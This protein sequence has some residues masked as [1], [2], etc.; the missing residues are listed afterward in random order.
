MN[1]THHL[2]KKKNHGYET[3]SQ[4]KRNSQSSYQLMKETHWLYISLIQFELAP[5]AVDQQQ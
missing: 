4:K 5:K 1:E 3:E 2:F